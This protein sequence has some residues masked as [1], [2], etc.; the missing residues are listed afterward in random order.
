MDLTTFDKTI[1]PAV[2]YDVK[3]V[4]ETVNDGAEFT[5]STLTRNIP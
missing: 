3:I 4:S 5:G 1:F 2:W